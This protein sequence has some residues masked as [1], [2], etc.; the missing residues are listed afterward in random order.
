VWKVSTRDDANRQRLRTASSCFSGFSHPFVL[1]DNQELSKQIKPKATTTPRNALPA[2]LPGTRTVPGR[3][4]PASR[5]LKTQRLPSDPQEKTASPTTFLC[6]PSTRCSWNCS[7]RRPNSKLRSPNLFLLSKP[8]VYFVSLKSKAKR[9]GTSRVGSLYHP[10]YLSLQELS[11]TPCV[12]TLVL[13]SIPQL[14]IVEC[15]LARNRTRRV[16][17]L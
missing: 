13:K 9:S 16:E 8:F 3:G 6:P 2:L 1:R 11:L 15:A 7:S 12:I 5:S 10:L 14:C 4:L 17:N